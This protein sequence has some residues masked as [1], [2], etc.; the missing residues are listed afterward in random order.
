[1]PTLQRRLSMI[2]SISTIEG[3]GGCGKTTYF[4]NMCTELL[5]QGKPVVYLSFNKRI[6]DQ[7]T[8]KINDK[9]VLV[10]TIHSLM[11]Q[12]LEAISKLPE[13]PIDYE[14]GNAD[15]RVISKFFKNVEKSFLTLFKDKV[16]NFSLIKEGSIIFVDEFQNIVEPNLYKCLKLIGNK[17]DVD[18]CFIGDRY[19]SIYG[20][21]G[22]CKRNFFDIKRDFGV[23]P[24]DPTILNENHRSNA[25]VLN[26]INSY[27]F[28]NLNI[29]K[30]YL[31]C[32]DDNKTI[33]KQQVHFFST[34]KDELE[35]VKA[36]CLRLYNSGNQ[37]IAIL[38]RWKRNLKLIKKWIESEGIDWIEVST[39]HGYIGNEKDIVFIV[40][41]EYPKT[42]DEKMVLYTGLIRAKERLILTSSYPIFD[43]T[44]LADSSSLEVINLQKEIMRPFK[45]LK[46]IKENKNLTL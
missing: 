35:Y 37:T 30:R 32:I 18:Y 22:H 11:Y 10:S 2:R 15:K 4:L 21:L 9:R 23:E 25:S 43:S 17:I 24:S 20:Y 8:N 26:F 41:L 5:A 33:D 3:L 13:K 14:N 42:T 6:A 28:N 16:L 34:R 40:G 38:S 1:M 31:Y 27:L 46:Q 12:E 45:Q 29:E 7:T 36:E 44:R 19:Q 39:I